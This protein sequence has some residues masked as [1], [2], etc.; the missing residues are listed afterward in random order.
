MWHLDE[1]GDF[2]TK[3]WACVVLYSVLQ[4]TSQVHSVGSA[5]Y[6]RQP[7]AS[8]NR[9]RELADYD[10]PRLGPRSSRRKERK[11]RLHGFFFGGGG[12][13]VDTRNHSR[14]PHWAY[15]DDSLA[16]MAK[17][18]PTAQCQSS[19]VFPKRHV[20]DLPQAKCNPRVR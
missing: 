19:E 11:C 20:L 10:D 3:W 6:A 14:E 8:Q 7:C 1:D 9:H 4:I 12:V 18:K 15:S 16:S 5:E 13:L 2:K 17:L